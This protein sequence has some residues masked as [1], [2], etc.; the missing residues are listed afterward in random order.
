[1]LFKISRASSWDNEKP[2]EDAEYRETVMRRP[3]RK[4][5]TAKY[6]TVEVNTLEELLKYADINR[7]GIIVDKNNDEYS[8]EKTG[9]KYNILIYDDYI[10]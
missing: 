9:C 4:S 10:E 7:D 5:Y 1:M 6:Y 8:A 2:T 3:H